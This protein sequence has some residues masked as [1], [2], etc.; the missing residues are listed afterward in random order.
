MTVCNKYNKFIVKKEKNLHKTF[1]FY[2]YNK[3]DQVQLWVNIIRDN[4]L[5]RFDLHATSQA[6]QGLPRFAL[7][8][9]T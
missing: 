1:I 6:L 8:R 5:F 9:N 3:K 7:L 2:I 4:I